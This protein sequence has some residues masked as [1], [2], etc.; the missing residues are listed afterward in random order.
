MAGE[1]SPRLQDLSHYPVCSVAKLADWN[2]P[3]QP[4]TA[5]RLCP[6]DDVV[7]PC[8]RQRVW[9][10]SDHRGASTESSR[11]TSLTLYSPTSA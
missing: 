4:T 11:P 10:F 1:A 7:P 5:A 8:S 2:A 6:N 3:P 9:A